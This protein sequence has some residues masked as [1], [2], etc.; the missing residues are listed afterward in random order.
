CFYWLYA[1]TN[2]SKLEGFIN[3]LLD[4]SRIQAG[5]L[6]LHKETFNFDTLV[7]ETVESMNHTAM[8]HTINFEGSSGV[9]LEADRGRI[10]Q[11]I[12]N[13]INNAI[14]YSPQSFK[15]W[16]LVKKTD[17]HVQLSVIDSG[18]GIPVNK[19]DKIFDR[20]FR[21]EEQSNHISGLGIGLN[22][23]R[24]I[25][26]MHQGEIGVDSMEGKGSTFYFR[27]PI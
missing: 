20:F 25:I 13:F 5:K 22:I 9:V 15:V 11:V 26:K 16:V 3:D 23:C 6:K 24:D 8:E 12:I 18:I 4:V 7:K 27:L 2:I 1:N 10:E 21:I 17:K 19:V 14:K